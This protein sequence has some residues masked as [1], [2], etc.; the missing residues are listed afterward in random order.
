MTTAEKITLAVSVAGALGVGALL[1]AWV[2]HLLQG[3]ERKINIADKLVHSAETL[4][5]RMEADLTRAQEA[6]DKAQQESEELRQELARTAAARGKYSERVV[7]LQQ[8]LQETHVAAARSAIDNVQGDVRQ[9]RVSLSAPLM[10]E[11]DR[12]LAAL[13]PPS[14]PKARRTTAM[15]AT[16]LS[17]SRRRRAA[18]PPRDP[19][20]S[21]RPDEPE[22]Q[23][24]R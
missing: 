14:K 22:P 18:Q 1:Q 19:L 6:L 5:T 9:V 4:M 16:P 15:R 12:E 2:T 7:E 21:D 20:D 11:L 23:P 17:T 8:K 10:A 13:L 3:R 24:Q